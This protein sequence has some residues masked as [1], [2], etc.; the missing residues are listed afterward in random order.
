[1]Q[2]HRQPDVLPQLLDQLVGLHR[3]QHAGHVLDADRVG[4]HVLQL[5]GELDVSVY[6]VHRGDGVG[7]GRLDHASVLLHGAHCHLH[8]AVVVE[9]VEYAEDVDPAPAGV[10]DEL[11][12]YVVGVVPVTDHVLTA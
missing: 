4:T 12:Q 6:G 11:V 5:A 8:V 10:L 2:V 7:Y 1:M 3:R 9:R